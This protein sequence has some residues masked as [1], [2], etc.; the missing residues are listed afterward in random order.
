MPKILLIYVGKKSWKTGERVFKEILIINR[1]M[2]IV[3]GYPITDEEQ[4]IN[5]L[6]TEVAY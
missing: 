5:H 1:Y 6:P 2:I 3:V 4:Q